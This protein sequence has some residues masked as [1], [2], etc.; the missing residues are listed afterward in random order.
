MF[1]KIFG[2][3]LYQNISIIYLKL[4]C[5]WASYILF[6]FLVLDNILLFSFV[7]CFSA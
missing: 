7:L 5:N 6:I 2:T 4:I 1:Y 3:Y